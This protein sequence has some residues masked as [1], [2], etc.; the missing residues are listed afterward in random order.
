MHKG[1]NDASSFSEATRATTFSMCD[2]GI[3]QN[4]SPVCSSGQL[5]VFQSKLLMEV[6]IVLFHQPCQ[7]TNA[8]TGCFYIRFVAWSL[9]PQLSQVDCF[10]L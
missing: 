1:N 3:E 6:F 9:Q 2:D 4:L 7:C 5:T 8:A 10:L